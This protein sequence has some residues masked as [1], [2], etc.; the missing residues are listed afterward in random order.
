[1]S[2]SVAWDNEQQTAIRCEFPTIWTWESFEEGWAQSYTLIA[3]TQQPVDVI[4]DLSRSRVIP[5]GITVHMRNTL[6]D[7]PS[8]LGFILVV[9]DNPV[10]DTNFTVLSRVHKAI[11]ERLIVLPSLDAARIALLHP[12]TLRRTVSPARFSKV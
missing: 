5:D 10:I 3:S 7:A 6:A 4:L 11:G 12:Y 9:T 2:I 8:N 1:M